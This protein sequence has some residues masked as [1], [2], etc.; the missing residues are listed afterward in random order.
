MVMLYL[1]VRVGGGGLLK[2]ANISYGRYALKFT[3]LVTFMNRLIA[4]PS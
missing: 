3:K 1:K 4:V 2:C